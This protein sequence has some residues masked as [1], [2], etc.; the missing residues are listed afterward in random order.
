MKS[1]FEADAGRLGYV[2]KRPGSRDSDSWF[3]PPKYIEAV[4]AVL[5]VID[6]DPFSSDVANLTVGASAFYTEADDA[7]SQS[8]LARNVFMNPPYGKPCRAAVEKFVE[9][10]HRR[11][12]QTGIV[13]VNN[14]TE[15][16]FF[17]LLLQTAAAVCF[18]NHRIS[19]Y[20]SDG[21]RISGN[22]RGQCFFYLSRKPNV[23]LFRRVFTQF[24]KVIS[25]K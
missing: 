7:F 6:L 16:R 20:N 10:F 3:T 4:R 11:S 5:G 9:E 23:A 18:T 24:G 2:G 8:W 25:C 12:F 13:L 22:T 1:L 19:F 17:Q 15:T 21:K 14:A